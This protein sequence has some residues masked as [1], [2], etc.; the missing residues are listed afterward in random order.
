MMFA[1]VEMKLAQYAQWA[2]NPLRPLNF[3]GRSIYARA[4]PDTID[5]DALPALSDEEA[6][7][8]GNALLAL[9]QHQPQSHRAIEARFF[10][11]MA[12]DEIGRRCG[13]GTRKR[14]HEIRQRGYA[15]LQ[16]RLSV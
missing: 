8:V 14:V 1:E 12:D 10:F 3:P 11:R 7:A 15:F 2:G 16:G 13:L 6:R 5:E 9:K 4:I